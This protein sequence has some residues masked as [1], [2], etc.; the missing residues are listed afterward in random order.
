M[1]ETSFFPRPHFA[2]FLQADDN[3]DPLSYYEYQRLQRMQKVARLQDRR[4]KSHEPGYKKPLT[5]VQPS[6]AHS[7]TTASRQIFAKP[8]GKHNT[9]KVTVQHTKIPQ[10]EK[11]QSSLTRAVPEAR[12]EGGFS[13]P[14]ISKN[15]KSEECDTQQKSG[16]SECAPRS[17]G[18]KERPVKSATVPGI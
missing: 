9:G 16:L 15:R 17:N 13:I 5:Q 6:T 18:R 14:V 11:R 7:Q 10:L 3:V 12:R 1:V 4:S 2:S 8:F